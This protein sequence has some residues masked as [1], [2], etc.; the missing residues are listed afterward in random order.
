[1]MNMMDRQVKGDL[2]RFKHFIEEPGAE[3][4]GYHGQL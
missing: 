4:G 1:M 2:K 3:S